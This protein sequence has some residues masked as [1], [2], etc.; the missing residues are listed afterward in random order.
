MSSEPTIKQAFL[1][2][3]E[4]IPHFPKTAISTLG[5]ELRSEIGR[6]RLKILIF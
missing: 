6:L 2:R 3:E 1:T 4:F 5:K